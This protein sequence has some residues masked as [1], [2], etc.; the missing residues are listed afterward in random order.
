MDSEKG[1][2]LLMVRA[3]YDVPYH[4]SAGQYVGKFLEELRDN[5]RIY[6]NLCPK[7]GRGLIPPRPWCARCNVRMGEWVELSG[8]GTVLVFSVAEQSFWDSGRGGMTPVSAAGAIIQLDGAPVLLRHAL[9]E[10]D[11]EKLRMGMRVEAVLRPGEQRMGTLNDILHFRT[12]ED[13][14][15]G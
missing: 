4:W 8:K 1:E 11:P 5:G 15:H 10:T 14:G 13:E 3:T 7:C 6:A 9:E 12:I 2:E